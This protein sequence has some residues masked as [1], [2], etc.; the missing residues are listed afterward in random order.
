MQIHDSPAC[1]RRCLQFKV[2]IARF[3]LI[4]ALPLPSTFPFNVSHLSHNKYLFFTFSS[5]P[6]SK[7]TTTIITTQT[8]RNK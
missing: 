5:V 4:T 3:V 7:S 1:A 2:S 6:Y 8:T